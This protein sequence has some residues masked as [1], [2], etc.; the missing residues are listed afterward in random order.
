M[1]CWSAGKRLRLAYH[2]TST[3]PAQ[4]FRSRRNL[5]RESAGVGATPRRW[6]PHRFRSRV[7]RRQTIRSLAYSTLTEEID[8]V[9]FGDSVIDVVDFASHDAMQAF[10]PVIRPEQDGAGVV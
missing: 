4:R 9:D 5:G 10:H 8:P 2:R 3:G 6:T 1:R 7:Q